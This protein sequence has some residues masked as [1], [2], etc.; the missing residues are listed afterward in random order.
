VEISEVVLSLQQA[1]YAPDGGLFV[2]EQVPLI[3]TPTFLEWGRSKAPLSEICAYIMSMFTTID[4]GTLRN[5][6]KAAF[7][8]F[9][10]GKLP[11]LPLT[12]CRVAEVGAHAGSKQ[13]F[14]LDTSCG[15][16]LSFKDI[17]QQ[18]VAQLLNH[19]LGA[20]KQKANILIETSGDTGPAAIAAVMNC[21]HINVFCMYPYQR[22][23]PV[24]ELQMV[25]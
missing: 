4:I 10:D 16:T 9:N 22:V 8:T 12:P 20:K 18:V 21:P 5:C 11:S 25:R 24:Q 15:P 2:P 3:N 13:L 17:G 6:T 23:S 14:L 7:S 1:T 19:V